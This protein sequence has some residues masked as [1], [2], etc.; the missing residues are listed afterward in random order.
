MKVPDARPTPLA[1]QGLFLPTAA[2]GA[3]GVDVSAYPG[4]VN[5]ALLLT[6]YSGDL[7]LDDGGAQSVYTL[8]LDGLVEVEGD[9][10][11]R[12]RVTLAPGETVRLPD[13]LGTVTFDGVA[14]FANFQVARDP[15][16]E[17][18]LVAALLLLAGLTVSLG[19]PRRRAWVRLLDDS[20]VEVGWRHLGRRRS[21]DT[22]AA[23]LSAAIQPDPHT[24][25][26][27]TT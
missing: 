11:E 5:P 6:A 19:V 20:T 16:K 10:G 9:D 8:D 24:H 7:G 17:I 3:D 2:R 26:E 1:L 23:A 21:A 25:P 14:R 27:S 18:S 4:L 12:W 15:G 13:G 22:D